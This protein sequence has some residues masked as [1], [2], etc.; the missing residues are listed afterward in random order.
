MGAF[1]SDLDCHFY[2][3]TSETLRGLTSGGCGGEISRLLASEWV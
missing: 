1:Q 3:G 2:S